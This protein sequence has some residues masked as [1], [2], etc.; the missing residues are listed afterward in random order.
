ML[1]DPTWI[2][3]HP[4]WSQKRPNWSRRHPKWSPDEAQSN[5]KML[6]GDPTNRKNIVQQRNWHRDVT[7]HSKDS[8]R[9]VLQSEK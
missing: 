4:N 5:E 8:T 1:L 2:Q 9:R 7:A 3:K 6:K